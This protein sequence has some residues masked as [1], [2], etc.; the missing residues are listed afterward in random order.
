MSEDLAKSVWREADAVC[1]DVDSTV[2]R[3]EGID[4]LA[5]F[6]GVAEEVKAW[7]R[8]AMGGKVK[9][10]DSLKARLNI[11]NP[12]IRDIKSFNEEHAMRKYLTP[13]V[14][15]LIKLLMVMNKR[16]F[17]VSGGFRD[18][19]E[20]LAEHLGIPEGHVYANR[21]MFNE[22]GKL[23]GVDEEEPTCRTGGKAVVAAKVK[24]MCTK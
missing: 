20:P 5:A 19:I 8:R 17:L 16:V 12:T 21:M 23:A 11:V 22:D 13:R 10:E 9:F 4:E 14:D 2:V 18:V 6:M 15:E 1:F 7:T 24:E 3:V